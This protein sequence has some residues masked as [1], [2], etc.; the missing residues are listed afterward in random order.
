MTAGNERPRCINGSQCRGGRASCLLPGGHKSPEPR[1]KHTHTQMHTHRMG[2]QQKEVDRPLAA[3]G[4]HSGGAG[5]NDIQ[6]PMP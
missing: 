5:G 2:A 4:P 3:R 6:T 1:Q